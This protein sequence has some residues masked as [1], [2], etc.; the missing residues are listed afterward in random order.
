MQL[1]MTLKLFAVA[2]T[3][4]IA[5]AAVAQQAAQQ[6]PQ[7]APETIEVSDQQLQQFAD[8]QMEIASIQK[9]FRS[10]LQNVEDPEKAQK[11]QREA[12]E[13]MTTAVEEVGLD[14]ESFNQIAM[15]IQSDPELQQDLTEMLQQQ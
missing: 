2:A 13:E 9:D 15:A 3:L 11:L 10:R 12:N 8:A 14:V 6:A 7:S 4:L 5:S 1:R